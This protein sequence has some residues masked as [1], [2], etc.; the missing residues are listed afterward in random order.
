MKRQI[1]IAIFIAGSFLISSILR[2]QKPI[3]VETL[4]KEMVDRDERA[5]F[6]DPA[7][8]CKQFS[9]Y[10]RTTVAKDK[11]GWFAN[12]DRSMFIRVD[13]N[14]G[15]KEFVMMDAEGPGSIVRF[16]MTFAGNKAGLGTLRIYIDDYQ[17]PVIQGRAFD[18]LSG[19]V[20]TTAPLATA[21]SKLSPY[22]YAGHNLYFPIP[23]AKSCKVTYESENLYEDDPGAKRG[24]TEAVYYNINY[25]TYKKGTPVISYSDAEMKKN[26]NLISIIQ[27]QLKEKDRSISNIKLKRISLDCDLQPGE[28]KSFSIQ[29]MNAIRQL[30]M[31]LQATNQEQALRSTI[32]SISFDG[33]K[34]VWTPV[35]DFFGIG[36]KPLYTSTWYT[37][38]EKSGSMSA[39]WV[40]PF[41]KECTI[42]L[43][44]LGD[45]K[46]SIQASADY[47]KWKWDNRSMHFGSTWQQYTHVFPG[48]EDMAL[49]LNFAS[50]EGKGIYMG[51]G[52]TLFN[53]AYA[54]WG[55]GDEKVYVDGEKFPSHIGTGSEDYYGYAWCRSEVFTDHP[56]IA[57]PIG[58]GNFTPDYTVNTRYR[59]LDAIP[60]TQSIQFDMELWHWANTLI[61]Y[62]P[63]SYW[64]MI[65]GGKKLT[66]E[67]VD[68][69]KE[70]VALKR[71]D[72]YS[73]QLELSVEAENIVALNIPNEK[74]E[75]QKN[76]KGVYWSGGM[77]LYWKDIS[78][79]DKADFEFE[80]LLP[81]SYNFV[82]IF[83]IAPDYGKFNIYINGKIIGA[84]LD[85]NH[86]VIATK[87]FKLGSSD[88][89]AGKNIFTVELIDYAK[90]FNK[91]CFGIDKLIFEK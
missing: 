17:Q 84:N 10:D 32:I 73:S 59:S 44:N 55:E 21:V 52:V 61:N 66:K 72:I 85:L 47:G 68:G 50:L 7:F 91:S 29:A 71:S 49:D 42:T 6:P 64:Y 75:F 86:I 36:Y 26:Q 37:Q 38:V 78:K 46:V 43:S 3:S 35:G 69:A 11:P 87:R 48:P 41:E 81:G 19:T 76:F 80:C 30:T 16:W 31:Q 63:V 28:N 8:T 4:L 77:Q 2:A 33:E 82:G 22:E 57:Q 83:T 14:N 5:R 18:V 79:G 53:T 20:V 88:L 40:M 90:G 58:S 60:F 74:L 56:F 34:T 1:V 62:A 67:D 15:R 12:W 70:R 25:R 65:P 39:F 23:Y 27:K 54:W 13:K 51:D 9:S 24:E 45:Q 89:K